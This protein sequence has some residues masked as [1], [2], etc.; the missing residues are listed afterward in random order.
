MFLSWSGPTSRGIALILKEWLSNVMQHADPWC[1]VE[2][3]PAGAVW[4]DRL[5]LGLEDAKVG[6]VCVT[7]HNHQAPWVLFE[8]GS[9]WSALQS[10]KV[11]VFRYSIDA[12]Q[13]VGPLSV[14]QSHDGCSEE[15]CWQMVNSL[16]KESADGAL[17]DVKM[18]QSFDAW[19]PKLRDALAELPTAESAT[20][21]RSQEDMLEEI[22][23][24]ARFS[25][26]RAL[27]DQAQEPIKRSMDRAELLSALSSC[28]RSEFLSASHSSFASIQA[29]NLQSYAD[30][31]MLV[32]EIVDKVSQRIIQVI[33]TMSNNR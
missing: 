15:G 9:V 23:S 18:R 7:A 19:Y 13:V 14:F 31:G 29:G 28:I 10:K 12:A 8:A 30:R 11:L 20:P 2:D 4:L 25:E 24:L 17:S 26:H 33:G 27:M 6:I 3:I 16:N 5:R 21:K 1:S 22:L 32:D